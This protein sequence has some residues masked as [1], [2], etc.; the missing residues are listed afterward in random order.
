MHYDG[1]SSHIDCFYVRVQ[2]YKTFVLFPAK[3]C[4]KRWVQLRDNYRRTKAKANKTTTGQGAKKQK[5]IRYEKE[6]SFLNDI[7][8]ETR[9]QLS[10]CGQGSD[11]NNSDVDEFW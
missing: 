5:V 9:Q 8:I 4:K 6:L 7:L 3:E 11:Y 2:F 1:Q 10:N